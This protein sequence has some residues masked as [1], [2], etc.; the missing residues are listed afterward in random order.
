M[1]WLTSYV[2]PKI[3]K[4]VKQRDIPDNLWEKC[5]SCEEMV[6]HKDLEQNLL[7]CPKCNY[8]FKMK[9]EDR[10]KLLFDNGLCTLI[11]LPK[12]EEDPLDFADIKKYSERLKENRKKTGKKDAMSVAYG[13]IGA[14][15]VVVAVLDFNFMGGSMGM[16]VGEAFIAAVELACLQEASLIVVTASG[17]ARM[18]E[19][20]FSL[21]QMARTTASLTK[22]KEKGLPYIV[23]LT[24]PTTGGVTASFAMLGDVLI[25][26]PKAT[27]GFAGARVIEQTIREKLP[28]GFQ[29][30]EYLLDHG[31]LDMV[32]ERKNLRSQLIKIVGL[33]TNREPKAELL[34]LRKN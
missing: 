8:H 32:V 3:R 14:M 16:A 18:Q 33:L 5:P 22:L 11:E 12:V 30:S 31:M 15:P 27:I 4:I 29:Q 28:E 1:N 25:A 26:E 10:L 6:F 19:G 17:G 13:S 20:M 7:V 2:R 23:L 34:S 21:V 9:G 24:N